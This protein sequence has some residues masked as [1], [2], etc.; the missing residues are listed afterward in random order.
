MLTSIRVSTQIFCSSRLTFTAKSWNFEN[1]RIYENECKV[2][3]K[4]TNQSSIG[5]AFSKTEFLQS[6]F[7]VVINVT[8]FDILRLWKEFKNI[9]FYFRKL[10]RLLSFL[11]KCTIW[12]TYNNDF[13]TYHDEKPKSFNVCR[14]F[15]QNYNG[16]NIELVKKLTIF[17]HS[18]T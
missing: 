8:N 5:T 4:L 15:S 7:D 10:K 16:I 11:R 12:D 2:K 18:S 14:K 17:H 3:S 9:V 1:Q 13:R 6:I